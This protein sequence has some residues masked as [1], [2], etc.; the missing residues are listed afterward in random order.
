MN[1]GQVRALVRNQADVDDDDITDDDINDFIQLRYDLINAAED[2]P[3]LEATAD[4]SVSAGATSFPLP[5][6]DPDPL[7]A[8]FREVRY[9]PTGG[10]QNA[11]R[12]V[13]PEE[14]P[15]VNAVTAQGRPT[16]FWRVG[17]AT[18]AQLNRP[19]DGGTIALTYYV[20]PTPLGDDADEPMFNQRFH[21]ALVY[22]TLVDVYQRGY[23]FEEAAVKEREFEQYL[24]RM[25][26]YYNR[27]RQASV[28]G[29]DALL[30]GTGFRHRHPWSW[31]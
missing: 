11:L 21:R 8:E 25:S 15:S 9:N 16:A 10:T 7:F 31:E 13:N 17:A 5:D 14:R 4:I 6:G 29:Q 30:R 28:M 2:W 24:A 20:E 3:Y 22:G 12:Q 27:L 1:R 19:V 23:D 18:D 26:D